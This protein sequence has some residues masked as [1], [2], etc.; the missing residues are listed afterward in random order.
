MNKKSHPDSH[1]RQ[2]NLALLAIL[3]GLAILFYFIAFVRIH[4]SG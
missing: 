2:R 1:L 3:L 4:T